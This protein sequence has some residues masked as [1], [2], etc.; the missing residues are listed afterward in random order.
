MKNTYCPTWESIKTHQIPEWYH[1]CKLGIFIHWGLYSVPA[2]ATPTVELGV[3]TDE[4]WF[5]NNPYAEWYYNSLKMGSGETYDYHLKTYGKDFKYE[6][7]ADIWKAEKFVPEEWASL[8]QEAGGRLRCHG[9][10]A[11]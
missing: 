2:F 4:D 11:P 9:Y 1:D 10:E 3:V 8:F 5:C 6:D 7:F